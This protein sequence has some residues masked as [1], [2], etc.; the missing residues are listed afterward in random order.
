MDRRVV[1]TG[2]GAVTPL[3]NNIKDFWEGIKAGKNGIARITHFDPDV[4]KAKN[5]AEVRNFE[6]YD[7]KEARRTDL[8]SQYGVTAA[9]EAMNDSG[10]SSGENIDPDRL[11]VLVGSGIGG[12][13]TLEGEVQKAAE[14]GTV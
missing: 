13:M 7:K 12:I 6:F 14:K 4:Q 5:G 3:G 1:I 8:Y 11:G 10:L 2:M 9:L